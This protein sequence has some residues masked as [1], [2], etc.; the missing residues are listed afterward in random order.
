MSQFR[1]FQLLLQC[2]LVS[3]TI[4]TPVHLHTTGTPAHLQTVGAPLFETF[5]ME[6]GQLVPLDRSNPLHMSPEPS[7]EGLPMKTQWNEFGEVQHV[8][9]IEMLDIQTYKKHFLAGPSWQDLELSDE[10]IED[11]RQSHFNKSYD[12]RP[13]AA[14][15]HKKLMKRM[16]PSQPIRFCDQNSLSVKSQGVVHSVNYHSRGKIHLASQQICAPIKAS[17]SVALQHQS[18]LAWSVSSKDMPGVQ[19]VAKNFLGKFAKYALG[20]FKELGVGFA[21]TESDSVTYTRSYTADCVVPKTACF[22]TEEPTI[23]IRKGDSSHLAFSDDG[24]RCPKYDFQTS[25]WES[26]TLYDSGDSEGGPH[27]ECP[28]DAVKSEK[29]ATADSV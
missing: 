28:A 25:G 5:V 13:H 16:A 21:K 23:I 9:Q 26:H 17:Y 12:P 2:L 3:S 18:A 7:Y 27:R 29:G 24:I 14:A 15:K 20:F 4:A 11:L 22:L 1:A 10:D 6:E 8:V 19:S